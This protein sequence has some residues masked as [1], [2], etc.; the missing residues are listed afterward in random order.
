MTWLSVA[1][2]PDF[3]HDPAAAAVLTIMVPLKWKYSGLAFIFA[4][5]APQGILPL[6]TF[7]IC[8]S[9]WCESIL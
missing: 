7:C 1:M 5:T 8:P 2:S 6:V 9:A 4:V 3:P